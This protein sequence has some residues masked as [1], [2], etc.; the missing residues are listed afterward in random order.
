MSPFVLLYPGGPAGLA[1]PTSP[2][3]PLTQGG[4]LTLVLPV[5]FFTYSIK[6]KKATTTMTFTVTITM[7]ITM[8][9]VITM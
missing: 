7:M 5:V 2:L 4:P 3:V 6:K 1:G 8:T 9:I